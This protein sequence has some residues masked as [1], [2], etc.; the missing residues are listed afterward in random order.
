MIGIQQTTPPPVGP[1]TSKMLPQADGMGTW[2]GWPENRSLPHTLHTSMYTYIYL[3]FTEFKYHF[4]V[5]FWCIKC[6]I[7]GLGFIF[8]GLFLRGHSEHS[9]QCASCHRHFWGVGRGECV[10]VMGP[11]RDL[12]ERYQTNKPSTQR[13]WNEDFVESMNFF[14]DALGLYVF[15]WVCFG[16]ACFFSGA[17]VTTHRLKWVLVPV[18]RHESPVLMSQPLQDIWGCLLNPPPP[19]WKIFYDL[20]TTTNRLDKHH[21]H[22]T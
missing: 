14:S 4:N 15:F 20:D 21:H 2:H 5:R 22:R 10:L 19:P 9:W 1:E 16:F 11:T 6:F 18:L 3:I 8:W 7:V 17:H 12:S 13:P